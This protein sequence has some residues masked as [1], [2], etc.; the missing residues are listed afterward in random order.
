MT[1]SIQKDDNTPIYK[2][3]VEHVTDS[4]RSGRAAG[5]EMLPSMNELSEVLDIS[6]ETVKKAYTILRDK[7]FIE[8]RQ[9]KG[10]FVKDPEERDTVRVLL[11]FDKL[12]TYKDRL[13]NAMTSK[14][15]DS[16]QV[17]IRLHNQS[18]DLFQYYLDE[19]LDRFDYYVITPHFP[20]DDDTQR[21]VVKQLIRIPNRKLIMLDNWTK[22][23]PGNYGAV[24]QDF[25]H[26]IYGGLLEGLDS[27]KESG[28]LSVIT[29]ASSLYHDA[30][31]ASVRRFC[32]DH[33][34]DVD[35]YNSVTE[36][37]VKRGDVFLL[38]NS[39]LDSELNT[40]ARVASQKGYVI[41]RDLCIISYNDSPINEL[42]LGG[43]TTVSTDF[44]MMGELAARMILSKSMAKIKSDFHLI[45]RATF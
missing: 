37:I 18:I 32:R 27:L 7:G 22:D 36:D 28:H 11:I 40:L 17:T 43:L 20:L 9:G 44:E 6:K 38:L 24:Y 25:S 14:I 2:Q 45:R 42:V 1:F 29:L 4:I 16:A 21:R 12:S 41:G 34:I 26:D 5:G 15:G 33:D 30:I 8:A 39:Q 35:F 19:C 10:F 3:L 13:L 23:L 31:S